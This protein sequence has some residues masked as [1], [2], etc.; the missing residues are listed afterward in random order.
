MASYGKS[1]TYNGRS[2]AD[3]DLVIGGFQ[4]IDTS[5]NLE[6]TITKSTMNRFRHRTNTY[7]IN[8]ND[9]LTFNIQI[10]KDPCKYT[11][12]TDMRFTREQIREIA[13]WLTSP[14]TP[15]IFHMFDYPDLEDGEYDYYGIFTNI[16]AQDNE[17]Y[18]LNCL[19]ECNTPYALSA[20]Q[21]IIID[22]G[23]GVV[24]NPSDEYED[25][26]YPVIVI[27]PTADVDEPY[28]IRLINESDGNRSI[29]L[30]NMKPQDT[31]TMDCQ[32]MTVKN[33]SGSLMSL[34]DLNIDVVDYIYWFR[35]LHGDNQIK[36]TGDATVEFIFRYP[37]KVGAY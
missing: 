14:I 29:T 20:E 32:K 13:A 31:V 9:V 16:S 24:S 37:I 22:D 8:Y 17:I 33:Q 12:Q 2:S 7:G 18:C 19:F 28:D 27:T 34:D 15:R 11:D 4:S 25:Y 3:F 35:L 26:V 5:L 6:R 30:K 23:E 10:I 1:F 36:V 21:N